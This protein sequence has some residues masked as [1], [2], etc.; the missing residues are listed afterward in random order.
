MRKATSVLI[1]PGDKIE[2]GDGWGGEPDCV[3]IR[4]GDDTSGVTFRFV[5]TDSLDELITVLSSLALRMSIQAC[6][7][8]MAE[9]VIQR[10]STI[11]GPE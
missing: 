6:E 2:L 8:A 5:D 7:R 10:H 11:D 1:G 9:S 4:S 3:Q